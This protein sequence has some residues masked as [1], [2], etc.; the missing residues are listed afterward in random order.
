MS[1]GLFLEQLSPGWPPLRLEDFLGHTLLT[2]DVS[3][4]EPGSSSWQFQAASSE[5]F[6]ASAAQDFLPTF[7]NDPDLHFDAEQS[8]QGHTPGWAP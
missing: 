7:R 8:G 2:N 3:C 5:V 1:T 4:C 6:H